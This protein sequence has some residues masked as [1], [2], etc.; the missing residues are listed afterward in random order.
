MGPAVWRIEVT[1]H[2]HTHTHTHNGAGLFEQQQFGIAGIEGVNFVD[3]TND[4]SHYTRPPHR[5]DG[6]LVD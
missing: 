4:A 1:G 2:T 5:T 3:A 6:T